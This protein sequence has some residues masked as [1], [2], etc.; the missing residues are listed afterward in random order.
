[1]QLQQVFMNLMMNSFDAMRNVNWTRGLTIKFQRT[2]TEQELVFVSKTGIRLS[3]QHAERIF[4]ALFTTKPNDMVLGLR[5]SQT[6]VESH[7]SR[8]WAYKNSPRGASFS[9]TLS[10]NAGA[11]E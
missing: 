11:P 6:I 7:G 2:E 3:A 8:L 9:F 10:G 5:I 4:K 1:V